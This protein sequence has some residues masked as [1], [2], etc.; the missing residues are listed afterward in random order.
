MCCAM[1]VTIAA[2]DSTTSIE[3][4]HKDFFLNGKKAIAALRAWSGDLS[5]VVDGGYEHYVEVNHQSVT[6]YLIH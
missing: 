1:A 4:N 2:H 3:Q 6:E 5:Q